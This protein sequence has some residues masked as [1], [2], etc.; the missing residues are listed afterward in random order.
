MNTDD[1]MALVGEYESA[2]S[3]QNIARERVAL[4]E[5]KTAIQQVV[6]LRE[7]VASAL[8]INREPAYMLT[9]SEILSAILELRANGA[10]DA[11]QLA[12][13][14][15]E[16]ARMRERYFGQLEEAQDVYVKHRA[17]RTGA[18]ATLEAMTAERDEARAK[19]EQM[20]TQMRMERK[21]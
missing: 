8:G 3:S 1:I 11:R 16:C 5:L 7:Q 2:V 19:C 9:D 18:R 12:E 4:L 10:E 6:S 21:L 13:A 14:L 15:A 17:E 20:R